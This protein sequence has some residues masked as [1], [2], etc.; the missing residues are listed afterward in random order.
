MKLG[1]PRQYDRY[2]Y[3]DAGQIGIVPMPLFRRSHEIFCIFFFCFLSAYQTRNVELPRNENR[4]RHRVEISPRHSNDEVT[5]SWFRTL[6]RQYFGV[7]CCL[8]TAYPIGTQREAYRCFSNPCHSSLREFTGF[9]FCAASET[10][11][12]ANPGLVEWNSN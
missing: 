10:E 4:E 3:F 9:V 7:F 6:P 5:L 1:L 11:L 2:L 12:N 8:A